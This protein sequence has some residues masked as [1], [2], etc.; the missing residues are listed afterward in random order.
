MN[1][2]LKYAS[3]AKAVS[4]EKRYDQK[5]YE[6]YPFILS[7]NS[8]IL[9]YTSTNEANFKNIVSFFVNERYK[10]YGD[11]LKNDTDRPD[12]FKMCEE[13]SRQ[14]DNYFQTNQRHR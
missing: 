9:E 12:I 8:S 2:L 7:L 5:F 6:K 13:D 1:P 3:R 11:Y 14:I 10:E 4:L